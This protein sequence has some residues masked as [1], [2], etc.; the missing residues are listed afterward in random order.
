[1]EVRGGRALVSRLVL[2]CKLL[3]NSCQFTLIPEH[4]PMICETRCQ[5]SVLTFS[6]FHQSKEGSPREGTANKKEGTALC[7]KCSFLHTF[8]SMF[9]EL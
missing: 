6:N 8:D 1:M 4:M 5:C 3:Y 9:D 7:L 2:N